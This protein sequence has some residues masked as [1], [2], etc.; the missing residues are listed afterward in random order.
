METDTDLVSVY[1]WEGQ[2]SSIEE[3][4][5]ARDAKHTR[6]EPQ[7]ESTDQLALQ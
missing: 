6:E 5:R 1:K 7:T 3:R 2:M 4:A